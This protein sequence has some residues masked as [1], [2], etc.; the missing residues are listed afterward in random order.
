MDIYKPKLSHLFSI[1]LMDILG[2]IIFCV[3]IGFNYL[4]LLILLIVISL[5]LI[6][7]FLIVYTQK[8]Y[9]D[10]EG[11]RI[12]G[13][14]IKTHYGFKWQEIKRVDYYTNKMVFLTNFEGKKIKFTNI[15]KNHKQLVLR[16]YNE[17]TNRNS[18][19]VFSESF[20][21]LIENKK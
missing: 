10:S 5:S 1:I 13:K 20:L 12:K 11:I 15:W 16:V 8:L 4:I 2:S 14:F 21:N 9:I 3:V 17:I 6:P 18:E 7:V 19:C